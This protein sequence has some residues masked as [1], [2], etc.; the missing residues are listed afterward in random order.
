MPAKYCITRD[1]QGILDVFCNIIN[2]SFDLYVI[3]KDLS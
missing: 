3:D 1:F 2:T